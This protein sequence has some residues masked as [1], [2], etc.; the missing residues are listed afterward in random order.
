MLGVIAAGLGTSSFISTKYDRF[1]ERRADIEGH[2][3]TQCFRCVEESSAHRKQSF[4]QE[5]NPLKNNGYL[6]TTDLEKIAQDLKTDNK[7]CIFHK[8]PTKV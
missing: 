5:N 1:R 6:W 2:Y 4:E 3:A 8:N 7:L